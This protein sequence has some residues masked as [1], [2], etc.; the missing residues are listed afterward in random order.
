MSFKP[1]YGFYCLQ[2]GIKPDMDL[3]FYNF[4][5]FDISIIGKDQFSTTVDISINGKYFALT[6]DFSHERLNKILSKAIPQI[7]NHI[8]NE[9]NRDP[10]TNRVIE[11]KQEIEC[12]VTARLGEVQQGLYEE[13][14]PLIATEIT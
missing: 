5:I 3:H 4:C 1:D 7:R 10:N 12:I 13:F 8:E 11:F 2:N 14:L 6:L 9:I